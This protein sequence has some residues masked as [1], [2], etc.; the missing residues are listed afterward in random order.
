MLMPE[1][2]IL[3]KLGRRILA[4]LKPT[5]TASLP[6]ATPLKILSTA[7]YEISCHWF[8]HDTSAPT[9]LCCPDFPDTSASFLENRYPFS[10][11]SVFE[12]GYNLMIFDP[13]G[14]GQSWGTED[15]G[16]LEHQ[17]NVARLLAWIHEQNPQSKIGVFSV[18]CGLS[19]AIGGITSSGVPVDFLM[20]MEGPSDEEFLEPIFSLSKKVIHQH[21]WKERSP[22]QLLSALTTPYIR[23]QGEYDHLQGYDMRHCNRIFRQ[24]AQQKH[25]HFQLNNHPAGSYPP[26]P[27]LFVNDKRVLTQRITALLSSLNQG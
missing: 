11:A 13:A 22:V 23:I 24:L 4:R 16:G 10:C 2:E 18:G 7:G 20:D 27:H 17:D 3:I 26:Q 5:R 14:R 15:H 21:F 1:T 6:A 19:M 12:A 25:P 9:L 8:A